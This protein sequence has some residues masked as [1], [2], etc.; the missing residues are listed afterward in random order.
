MCQKQGRKEGR[1]IITTSPQN[2]SNKQRSGDVDNTAS[3]R[4]GRTY[5]MAAMGYA[6][7]G[8]FNAIFTVT[9]KV[10]A[11]RL[12]Q[13]FALTLGIVCISK[14]TTAEEQSQRAKK[15]VDIF[16]CQDEVL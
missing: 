5:T 8:C 6:D 13:G 15:M 4:L 11:L 12:R 7:L 1:R 9:N 16:F 14:I 3:S 2:I 10:D